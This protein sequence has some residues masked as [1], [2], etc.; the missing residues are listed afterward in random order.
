MKGYKMT[1]DSLKKYSFTDLLKQGRIRIPKIQRDYAQGRQLP[2]VDEIRKVF[3]HT[4]LLVVKGKHAATELDF[5]YGS[6]QK[7]A[8]EP[9]DGQQRLTTLFLLHW[10]FGTQ[11]DKEHPLFTYETRNTSAEFCEELVR[12]EALHFVHEALD[13]KKNNELAKNQED[14]KPEKPASIIRSKDWFKWEWQYDP[15]I[16]SMLVMIDAIFEEMGNEWGMDLSI[17]RNNLENIT[18]H[19]LN[20]GDFGLSNELFIKMNARGKQLSDFDKLKSTLEEE[21]QIQQ[22]ENDVQGQA[23]AS[24]KD[25]EMWRAL[26]DGAWIDLFWHK[27]ARKTILNSEETAS[28]EVQRSTRLKVAKNAELQFKKL[29]LRLIALQLFE[30]K[31]SDEKLALAAYELEES[32][33]DNLLFV[34]TNSLN[35]VRSN[36]QRIIDTTTLPTL[37]FKQLMEDMNLLIYKDANHIYQEISSLLPKI[38]HIAADN[39]ALFDSF[40][41]RKVSN[42]VELTFYAML[43]FLRAFPAKKEKKLETDLLA[44]YF[45][46]NT[47]MCWLKN[48]EDWVRA[49]RNILSNDNNNQRIDKIQI[50]KNATHA[51]VQLRD[52]LVSYVNEKGLNIVTD[53]TVVKQF[54]K[55]SNKTY[56]GL[57]NRS[58]E[59]EREKAKLILDNSTEWA[60]AFDIAEQHPYLWGQIRCLLKWSDNKLDLF[61]Q[62]SDRLLKLL[63]YM[64]NQ[65]DILN[66]YVAMLVFK[67]YYWTDSE[68]LF[69]Y[70]KDRDNSF[71]RYLRDEHTNY[72]A[73]IKALI[74]IW[75]KEYATLEVAEFL[76]SFIA[77]RE[78]NVESWIQCVLTYPSILN[79]S[80]YKR[81]YSKNGHVILAQKKT[82]DSHCFDIMLMYL[83]NYCKQKGIG[84]SKYQ[85]Y[86]SKS[87]IGHAFEFT[88]N[89]NK[90][91]VTWEKEGDGTYS[92]KKNENSLNE[93]SAK[94][95]LQFM[96]KIIDETGL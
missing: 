10:M 95:M 11:F 47:Q 59:E 65:K 69:V 87:D 84:E 71:K 80:G 68:R 55:S 31:Y 44:W 50:A 92:I 96:K 56:T 42:D 46:E 2:K 52:D 27:Y 5:V 66:F 86:D 76:K 32:K 62:Y 12:R 49:T 35:D 14:K 94:D 34:Y 6:N 9:L 70:D 19:L 93:Y 48:L 61:K 51:L 37:N 81:I 4:L 67:P 79:E 53:Q 74:E 16:L 91:L 73:D 25:E 83:R 89:V 58:L 15:T 78:P 88:D 22:K 8:F 82:D 40:L 63:D 60:T 77:D 38:S 13:N 28:S 39:R 85:F 43:L 41:E 30:N 36:E 90:Y 57:D 45:E 75:M 23:L 3:V 33:I 21:L 72:G 20:L 64:A 1:N 24:A 26:M 7:N 54:L 18:F 29:L 17:C